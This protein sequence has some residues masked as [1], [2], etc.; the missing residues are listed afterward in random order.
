MTLEIKFAPERLQQGSPEE[1]AA[2]G[3][4]TMRVGETLLTEGFD[5][6]IN[7]VRDG[8]LVSGYHAAQW[9]AWNWWRL[10]WEPRSSSLE[11]SFAHRMNSIGEGYVWPNLTVST[12]GVRTV[13]L[14]RPS[15]PDAKPFRYA[16]ALPVVLPAR[17]FE[18]AVD[19]FVTQV[20]ARLENEGVGDSNLATIWRDVQAERRDPDRAAQRKM[21]A[22][23]GHEPDEASDELLAI[24][25]READAL[26]R[27]AVEEMA[28]QGEHGIRT[29]AELS[30]I[31]AAQGFEADPRDAAG[32]A[33][34]FPANG[35]TP[36]WRIG[37]DAAR[38]LRQAEHLGAAPISNARLA[39]MTGVRVAAIK[40]HR[41]KP[42]FS[43]ALDEGRQRSHVVLSGA[44]EVNRRFALARLL[45]D[46]LFSGDGSLHPATTAETYR[47]KAQRSFAAELLS[48]FEVVDDMMAGDYGVDRQAE[49]AEHFDVSGMTINSLLKNH[50]RLER[51]AGD[52]DVESVSLA[53]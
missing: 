33:V 39:R 41:A 21:E 49:V 14:S 13:L 16:G 28:A 9:L 17:D 20:L 22:L 1:Q 26:G 10:R 30:E 50:G 2:F 7:A 40:Q 19:T 37:A 36:A 24:L 8:P 18:Q 29:S 3:L 12:D 48:P 27:D 35:A 46:R 5:S 53:A 25:R 32:L 43:F 45:G 52:F 51:D 31:A 34:R 44:H 23:L 4:F 6:F 11:W 38:A 47:Q 42:P 15:Q